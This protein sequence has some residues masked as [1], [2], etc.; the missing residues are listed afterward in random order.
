ME[1]LLARA[2]SSN[3]VYGSASGGLLMYKYDPNADPPGWWMTGEEII[4]NDM[5]LLQT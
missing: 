5:L 2:C 3:A 4:L 1:V